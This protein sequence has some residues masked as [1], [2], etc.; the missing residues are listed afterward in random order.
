LSDLT[1]EDRGPDADRAA[2]SSGR[3]A[4]PGPRG[5]HAGFPRVR[6]EYS[7]AMRAGR[8]ACVANLRAAPGGGNAQGG[9][10]RDH[11]GPCARPGD[12]RCRRGPGTVPGPGARPTS[13]V[14]RPPRSL[15][16]QWVDW[17]A[18]DRR[19]TG[20]RSVARAVPV[21]RGRPGGGRV[22]GGPCRSPR[23]DTLW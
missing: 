13:A 16:A 5:P 11:R 12:G 3:G 10:R 8:C 2:A 9:D 23:N 18:T 15:C 22:S 19:Y 6:F 20:A 7:N 1:R 21:R 17:F 14:A 4:T